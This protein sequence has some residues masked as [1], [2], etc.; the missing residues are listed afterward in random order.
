MRRWRT[1]ATSR[2]P[3][4]R[5]YPWGNDRPRRNQAHFDQNT[6]SDS[7]AVVGSHPGK[8]RSC[9]IS[10]D[11]SRIN[12][13]L[14]SLG[15]SNHPIVPI[16]SCIDENP[17]L[18]V[19]DQRCPRGIDRLW[20]LCPGRPHLQANPPP[21]EPYH[22]VTFDD[23]AEFHWT[24]HVR[25]TTTTDG[26]V[27]NMQPTDHTPQHCGDGAQGHCPNDGN[28]KWA[29]HCNH[30]EGAGQQ[31]THFMAIRL[32][33]DPA[34]GGQRGWVPVNDYD[35]QAHTH[36]FF[37]AVLH[38]PGTNWGHGNITGSPQDTFGV[39]WGVMPENEEEDAAGFDETDA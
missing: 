15:S 35:R 10:I 12:G 39:R 27:K 22:I 30:F 32:Y 13:L 33:C 23:G 18:H 11:L 20:S 38:V 19:A 36:W 29:G 26:N 1:S 2:G 4:G 31:Y 17:H 25:L 16:W 9:G 3:D 34:G 7:P 5:P 8:E 28:N 14:I 21:A 37:N 6:S 24:M